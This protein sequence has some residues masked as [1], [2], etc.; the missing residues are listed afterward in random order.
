MGDDDVSLA[1]ELAYQLF[2]FAF[3]IHLYLTVRQK[4]DLFCKL[5]TIERQQGQLADLLDAVPDSVLICSRGSVDSVPKGVYANR[6]MNKF[7]GRDVV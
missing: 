7:F 4:A 3:E 5:K 1:A 6:R 2:C